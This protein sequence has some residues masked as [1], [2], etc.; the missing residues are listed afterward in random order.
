MMTFSFGAPPPAWGYVH[1]YPSFATFWT[2]S[3][4]D[5]IVAKG[6]YEGP[7]EPL[8]PVVL[9]LYTM[10][11]WLPLLVAVPPFA[12]ATVPAGY[13]ALVRFSLAKL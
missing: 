3:S 5:E 9:S 12:I 10:K 8:S 1:E 6:V 7:D 11:N 4:P 13:V 2:I